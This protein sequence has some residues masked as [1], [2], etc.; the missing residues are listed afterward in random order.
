[1]NRPRTTFFI[2]DKQRK[3]ASVSGIQG[4]AHYYARI[5]PAAKVAPVRRAAFRTFHGA[6]PPTASGL[7][8]AAVIDRRSHGFPALAEGLARIDNGFADAD[9]Q[10]EGWEHYAQEN[11]SSGNLHR[12]VCDERGGADGKQHSKVH[13]DGNIHRLRHHG[14]ER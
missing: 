9:R 4:N 12:G 6:R 1:M 11:D 5:P 14:S 3:T 10:G 2:F 13:R 8:A 7:G